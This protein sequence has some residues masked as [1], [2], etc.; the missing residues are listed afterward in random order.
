MACRL[1]M[2]PMREISSH[3]FNEFFFLFRG[4]RQWASA[5][6]NVQVWKMEAWGT[7]AAVSWGRALAAR[8]VPSLVLSLLLIPGLVPGLVSSVVANLVPLRHASNLCGP[9]NLCSLLSAVSLGPPEGATTRYSSCPKFATTA[10][11]GGGQNIG[12]ETFVPGN[13]CPA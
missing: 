7:R 1:S 8:L 11:S 12:A 9:F 2:S 5:L 13:C 10:F 6:S 3:M 4:R